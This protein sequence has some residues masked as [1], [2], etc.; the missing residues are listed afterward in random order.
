MDSILPGPG[1]EVKL[2]GRPL[3]PRTRADLVSLSVEHGAGLTS[4][5][6]LQL[7]TWNLDTRTYTWVDDP[8]FQLGGEVEIRLGAS[9]TTLEPVFRGELTDL[10]LKAEADGPP[11]LEVSGLDPRHVLAR[12]QRTRRFSEKT[13]E[14][15]VARVVQTHGFRVGGVPTVSLSSITQYNQ[16]DLEFLNAL[17]RDHGCELTLSLK[18]GGKML[19]FQKREP[20][21]PVRLV[22]GPQLLE[23]NARVSSQSLAGTVTVRSSAPQG[24]KELVESARLLAGRKQA[25]LLL[26]TELRARGQ[27]TLTHRPVNSPAEARELAEAELGQLVS[28]AINGTGHCLGTPSLRVGGTVDLQGVGRRFSGEYHLTQVTHTFSVNE[29]FRTAFEVR[30][31]P[32]GPESVGESR[33]PLRGLTTARVSQVDPQHKGQVKLRIPWLA[34]DYE[35]DWVRVASSMA[36]KGHGLYLPLQ[37]EDEVVVAFEQGDIDRPLVLGGVW[38]ATAAP[39]ESSR[40]AGGAEE[41][42]KHQYALRSPGG[43]ALWF[44]DQARKIILGDGGQNQLVIDAQAGTLLLE[45]QGALN[46]KCGELSA[47]VREQVSVRAEGGLALNSP[48]GIKL[49]DGA[50]E[51][52]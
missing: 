36:G 46:L 35:S 44:D 49:N 39:P 18:D 31:G 47:R 21:A 52:V 8:R 37:V 12:E 25:G 13:L 27:R 29:G 48:A 11:L 7:R 2:A 24:E 45:S 5:C 3:D 51:V 19:H 17:A 43:L 50:L 32:W 10:E 15:L 38:S 30:G 14:Q 33:E 41:G 1:I 4:K 28:S 34:P 42:V 6:T 40:A 9:A 23:F 22:L 20:G 26:P 16:T